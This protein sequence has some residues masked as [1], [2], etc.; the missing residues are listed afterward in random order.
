MTG[1]TRS[2]H[3]QPDERPE[4]YDIA[5]E[6]M[7]LIAEERRRAARAT[8]E[9]AVRQQRLN[10]IVARI[11]TE[12]SA[13]RTLE[14]LEGSAAVQAWMDAHLPAVRSEVASLVPGGAQPRQS[15]AAAAER[16]RPLRARGVRVRGVFLISATHDPVTRQYVREA[17]QLG[18]EY[19]TV[20][21]L[22][23]RLVIVDRE[24]ALLP[25]KTGQ[26][27]LGAAVVRD[28]RALEA[29]VALF[30]AH[31]ARAVPFGRRRLPAEG[32]LSDTERHLL[33]ML[34]GGDRDEDVAEAL[35]VSVRTVRRQV[36]TLSERLG[37]AS[38]FQFGALA[39]KAGWLDQGG[40]ASLAL[41]GDGDEALAGSA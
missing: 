17:T 39:C 19:R 1:Q 36:A 12:T 18:V 5:S 33:R 25:L 8:A 27:Q 32:M 13:P 28:P 10:R 9:I 35:G 21:S 2:G 7:A 26:D 22:P 20:A 15:L 31:W 37:A 16:N 6:F 29:L 34:D 14:H 38:R 4:A 24:V 11:G 40:T 30:E 23:L 3:R 41:D